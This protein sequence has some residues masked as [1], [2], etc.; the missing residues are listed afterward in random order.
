MRRG[1]PIQ[2]GQGRAD[3]GFT[4]VE[5]V[6]VLVI[7]A[8]SLLPLSMLFATTSIRSGDAHNATVAAQLAEAKM[9]EIAADKNSPTRGYAYLVA[10]NYPPETPVPAFPGYSRSVAV[11]PD[12]VY[13]GVTFRTVRVTVT[14]PNIP[15][16]TLTTW[17][18]RY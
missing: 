5:V 2:A 18:T 4:L 7:A 3:S 6:L 1:I 12:S 9:E 8:V 10:G 11:A 17:F 15:P 13:D 16:I 14:S